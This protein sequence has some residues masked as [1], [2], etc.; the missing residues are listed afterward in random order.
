MAAENIAFLKIWL[1]VKPIRGLYV[2]PVLA[3]ERN[4]A[5]HMLFKLSQWLRAA[6]A[7]AK[8]PVQAS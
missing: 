4:R 2:Y 5:A 8:E 6:T 1:E 3:V 7:K